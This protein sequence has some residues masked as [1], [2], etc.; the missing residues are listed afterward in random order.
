LLM[1]VA[2]FLWRGLG[3]KSE[4]ILAGAT[5]GELATTAMPRLAAGA[6]RSVYPDEIDLREREGL[7]NELRMI[8]S[9][10]DELATLLRSWVADRRS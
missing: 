1:L 10:P 8:D 2:F 6:S 4:P 7:P 3:A 5:R 9:A